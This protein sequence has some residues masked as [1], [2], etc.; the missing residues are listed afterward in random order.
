MDVS[1]PVGL[2]DEQ[3]PTAVIYGRLCTP[4]GRAPQTVQLLVHGGAYNH[5]YWDAPFPGASYAR[6]AGLAG[7]ATLAIDR[8][9]AGRSTRPHSSAVTFSSTIST[10][11]Q[12][13]QSLKS[14]RLG[15]KFPRVEYVGH[16]FGSVYGVGL[17]AK[18][19][20]VDAVVLTGS[21]HRVSPSFS[22]LAS[23]NYYPANN[24]P[25]FA[26]LDPG[27]LTSRP[28]M[29][30]SLHYYAP[31]ADQRVIDYDEATKDVISASEFSTRPDAST[32]MPLIHVPVLIITGQEDVHYCAKDNIDCS[33]QRSFY[34]SEAPFFS[35]AACLHTILVPDTGHNLT[36]HRSAPVSAGLIVLWSVLFAPARG[37]GLRLCSSRDVSTAPR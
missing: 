25:R 5:T 12:V 35:P 4:H 15:V 33:T 36:M 30:G 8:I 32:L 19:G 37:P 16:S 29:I 9:G 21:G 27:W 2:G 31:G 17:A 26:S 34:K 24:E 6:A 1:V 11:H 22:E 18:Y 28:G 10:L 23:A 20:D 3:P 7:Y 14:G 13:V